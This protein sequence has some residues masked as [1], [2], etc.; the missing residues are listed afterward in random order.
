MLLAG[1]ITLAPVIGDIPGVPTIV[2][3]VVFLFAGQLL[4]GRKCFWLPRWLLR[5]S[6]ARDRL[7]VALG[8][9][10]R[11]ARF[12]DRFLRQGANA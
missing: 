8:W 1:L 4:F 7:D 2:G 11:P 12:C 6:I 3:A 9:L 5:R 10:R